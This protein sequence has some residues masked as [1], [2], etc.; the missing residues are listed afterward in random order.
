M[1]TNCF[2]AQY[3]TLLVGI[4]MLVS[5]SS[6]HAQTFTGQDKLTTTPSG[7]EAVVYPV[8]NK[9]STIRLN[10]DNPLPGGVRV[11]IRNEKGAIVYDEFETVANY[12]RNFDLIGM[13]AGTYTLELNKSNAHF[14]QAFTIEPPTLGRIAMGNRPERKAPKEPVDNKLI[15]S[16]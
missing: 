5:A 14:S 1:K 9:P 3:R 7:L 2:S 6:L 13:P 4:T 15:V 10:F 12:R 8:V 11:V 16:Y